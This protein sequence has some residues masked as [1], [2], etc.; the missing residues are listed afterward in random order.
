[1]KLNSLL[2]SRVFLFVNLKPRKMMGDVSEGMM[3]FAAGENDGLN[4]L[5]PDNKSINGTKVQ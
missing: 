5:Q 4:M 2:V 1:M 3:L